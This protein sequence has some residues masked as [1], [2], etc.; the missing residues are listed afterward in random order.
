[1]WRLYCSAL[2]VCGCSFDP[3]VSATTPLPADAAISDAAIPDAE[4]VHTYVSYWSFDQD[5]A[6]EMGVHDGNLT[7][8][9]SIS[10]G[11][12]FGGGESLLL[13]AEGQRVDVA[14]PE[15][16]D[17]NSDFTWHLYIKTADS[18]G[19][20][21]SRSPP[22]ESWNQG[23]KALFVRDSTV[24][25]DT[26]WVSNP[27]TGVDVTDEQWHQIIVTYRQSDDDF[28]IYVDAVA[29]SATPSHQSSHDVNKFDEHTHLHNGSIA[30]TGF[31][32]G[33]GNS[34]GGLS[35]LD[36]LV[37]QIDEVAI[38]DRVLEGSELDQLIIEGP[39]SF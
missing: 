24:Q 17:F 9:A 26:G 11:G 12:G 1:M 7:D 13:T 10:T 37:G 27:K 14:A 34:A 38:F 29:E 30:S 18:S 15:T 23:S 19:A 31:T 22:A 3:S 4:I 32:I 25:W 33:Q 5:G 2:F 21:L 20:L 28:K 35:S 36:T 8:G 6:D 16:F 39:S